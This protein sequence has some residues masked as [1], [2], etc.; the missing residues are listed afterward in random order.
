M[1]LWRVKMLV[2]RL[3]GTSW[4]MS[5]SSMSRR[6]SKSSLTAYQCQLVTQWKLTLLKAQSLMSQ[7]PNQFQP[8][9]EDPFMK[10][11]RVF[12]IWDRV[13]EVVEQEEW[14][15]SSQDD[16]ISRLKTINNSRWQGSWLDQKEATWNA[17]LKCAK[18]EWDLKWQPM[19][20]S[21]V[22]EVKDQDSA[23]GQWKKVTALINP[24]IR[25]TS[26]SVH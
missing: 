10:V 15:L 8:N 7:R 25:R 11:W 23:K 1:C 6:K 18:E 5:H 13:E 14:V 19:L 3:T 26:A 4:R 12:Q 24:R 9:L 22:W 2:L 21:Y 20:W 17:L 16:L